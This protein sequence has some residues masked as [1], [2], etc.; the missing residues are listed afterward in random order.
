MNQ[1]PAHSH[2][3][4]T[5]RAFPPHIR[6]RGKI[7]VIQAFFRLVK[8]RKIPAVD[9]AKI[10]LR[11]V[12]VSQ[13]NPAVRFQHRILRIP[14]KMNPVAAFRQPDSLGTIRFVPHCVV[15]KGGFPILHRAAGKLLMV[16]VRLF[17][18]KQRR[19]NARTVLP[20]EQVVAYNVADFLPFGQFQL[21][22][23]LRKLQMERVERISNGEVPAV[24]HTGV[25]S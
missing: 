4:H 21:R 24:P 8:N 5:H 3:D 14:F 17:V 20:M 11:P 16:I 2:R 15:K 1:V 19:Q 7:P 6:R 13:Q 23:P 10:I 9:T 18:S 22:F 12:F 25:F